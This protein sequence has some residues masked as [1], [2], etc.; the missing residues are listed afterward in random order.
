M[1][2][3][4][5]IKANAIAVGRRISH[6]EA[7]AISKESGKIIASATSTY[8]NINTAKENQKK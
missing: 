3:M 8:M 4:L 6:L 5:I 1:D 7:K 2:D